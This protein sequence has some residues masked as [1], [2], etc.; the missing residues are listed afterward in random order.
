MAAFREKVLPSSR[1]QQRLELL[2]NSATGN[3][4]VANENTLMNKVSIKVLEKPSTLQDRQEVSF[5]KYNRRTKF[6]VFCAF[7]R[8]GMHGSLLRMNKGLWENSNICHWG[9]VRCRRSSV[10]LL[11]CSGAGSLPF[12]LQQE[13]CS[14]VSLLTP[15][16]A[17]QRPSAELSTLTA[18]SWGRLWQVKGGA[19][20]TELNR[21]IIE[22]VKWSNNASSVRAGSGGHSQLEAALTNPTCDDKSRARS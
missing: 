20:V 15:L 17:L 6:C 16:T 13:Q 18:C 10:L 7:C 4:G 22:F 3:Q 2:P 1:K 5:K 12:M 9:G 21:T 14:S 11:T 8:S 19:C